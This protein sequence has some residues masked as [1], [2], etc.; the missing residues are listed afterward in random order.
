MAVIKAIEEIFRY[1]TL[2]IVFLED[3]IGNFKYVIN[4]YSKKFEIHERP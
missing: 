4:E 2:F 1:R 3:K